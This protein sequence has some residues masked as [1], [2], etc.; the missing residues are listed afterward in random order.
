MSTQSI[1]TIF[2][3]KLF[4]IP[5]YQRGYS[6]G[7]EQ[8]E[9]FW[10]DLDNLSGTRNHYTGVLT[11]QKANT[12]TLPQQW[13]QY[14]F[15]IQYN[16]FIPCYVVDGQQ[17]LTTIIILLQQIINAIPNG[18]G[19]LGNTK[20]ELTTKYIKREYA[21]IDNVNQESYIF[22][23]EV[24]DPSDKYLKAELFGDTKISFSDDE[25][26]VYTRNLEFAIK[27]FNKKLKG[28]T[29][30]KLGELFH[31]LTSRLQFTVYEME[32]GLDTHMIFETTN[33]RGKSLSKFNT[34]DSFRQLFCLF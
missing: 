6:W 9:D 22:G 1:S 15:L 30:E 17:R 14:Q 29:M 23:Y 21:N 4:R 31:K 13:N 32:N 20:T 16:N 19:I 25:M 2:N 8:L 12:A 7:V 28:I 3:Q 18:G 11:L 26:S 5:D 34:M 33:N 24:D 27:F 10:I